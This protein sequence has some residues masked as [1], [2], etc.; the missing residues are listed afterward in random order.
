MLRTF[1]KMH[2]IG[3]D[4][5]FFDC[6]EQPLRDP[7]AAAVR[8][9]DRHRSVGGDGIVLILSSDRADA[10]MRMFNLD[11]SEGMMCGNAIRCVGKYLFERGGIKKQTLTVETKSGIKTLFLHVNG[12]A[13]SSVTVDMGAPV[14]APK[15][16]PADFPGERAVNVPLSVNGREYR[17]TC[18]SMGNPHCVVFAEDPAALDLQALGPAFEHHP[19]FPA[20]VNTEFVRV[21]GANELVMR[22]WERGSGETRACGTG[23]C[24]AAVAAVLNGRCAAESDIAVR[25]LGGDL[26]IRVGK[27]R[28]F[29]TG[30]AALSFTGEVEL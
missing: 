12:G 29:M 15:E 3:N 13:V 2:G 27:D 7:S 21:A 4:Y 14:L 30:E 25:L 20:R 11:G 16:I 24:A 28:V 8:L 19:A 5:I 22:V 1:Y 17:V 6:R 18:V 23:A 9:S 26:T 10:R